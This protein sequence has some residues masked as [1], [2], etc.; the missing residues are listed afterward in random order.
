MKPL[1]VELLI[2]SA[3]NYKAPAGC[4]TDYDDVRKGVFAQWADYY[5]LVN[6]R[7]PLPE[8]RLRDLFRE[9]AAGWISGHY[10]DLV[11]VLL[12]GAPTEDHHRMACLLGHIDYLAQL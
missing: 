10:A 1:N 6:T 4:G 7:S 11:P 8:Y 3:A 9:K 5:V 12:E 2:L